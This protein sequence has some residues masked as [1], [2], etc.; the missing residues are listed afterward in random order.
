MKT[1]QAIGVPSYRLIIAVQRKRESGTQRMW[2]IV[3]IQ[4]GDLSP[5]QLQSVGSR[6]GLR[7]MVF[8]GQFQRPDRQRAHVHR[9]AEL[10]VYIVGFRRAE[11][12]AVLL[13]RNQV[14]APRR[15]P[16]LFG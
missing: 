1:I 13:I 15:D 16:R 14:Y 9:R 2:Y 11:P 10:P 6:R 12:V 5:R 7:I 4:P 3:S 8:I